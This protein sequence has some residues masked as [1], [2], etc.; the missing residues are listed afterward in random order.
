M[1]IVIDNFLDNPDKIQK[2]AIKFYRTHQSVSEK[3]Y[4]GKKVQVSIE[5]KNL[6]S[7]KI[8]S[9]LKENINCKESCYQFVDETYLLGIPHDDRSKKYSSIL[10]LNKNA[11]ENTGTQIFSHYNN[12]K[13]SSLYQ[14]EN[15]VLPIKEHFIKSKR[16]ILDK[17]M[18]RLT[19]FK[20]MKDFKSKDSITIE[21]KFNRMIIFDSN[22]VHRACNYF[23]KDEQSRL[24]LVS[25]F[26]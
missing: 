24:C 10:F 3:N 17:L 26:N 6:I 19:L 20:I 15:L 14:D 4:P 7:K 18:Y 12:Y 11:P 8:S 23:G 25:F 22:L 5:I 13:S 16:K 9:V 21:N 1:I 2:E